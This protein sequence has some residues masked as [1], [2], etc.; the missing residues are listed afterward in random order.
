MEE[1]SPKYVIPLGIPYSLARAEKI[2]IPD[3]ERWIVILALNAHLN[4]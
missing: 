4:A 1:V 2:E 3:A